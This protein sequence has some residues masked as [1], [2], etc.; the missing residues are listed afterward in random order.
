[1]MR[2][3]KEL[4][5]IDRIIKENRDLRMGRGQGIRGKMEDGMK[6]WV[7]VNE[8]LPKFPFY[9]YDLFH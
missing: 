2:V 8:R 4:F 7:R 6:K 9:Y 5:Y 3:W 1:M